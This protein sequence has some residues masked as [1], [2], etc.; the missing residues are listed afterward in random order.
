MYQPPLAD[1]LFVLDR[2]AGLPAVARLPGFD[3]ALHELA[4][5]VLAEAGRLASEVLADHELF[6]VRNLLAL[7]NTRMAN[8]LGLASIT[9]PT[10]IASCGLML[11]GLPEREGHLLRTAH[12]ALR[13]LA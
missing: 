2:V 3:E 1:M 7:R 8:L 11:S 5:A 12:A 9:V 10:G 6:R 13:G 4:P